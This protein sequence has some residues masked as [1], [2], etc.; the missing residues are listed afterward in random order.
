MKFELEPYRRNIPDDTFIEDLRK[1]AGQLQKEFVTMEEYNKYGTYHSSSI[2]NRFGSWFTALEKAGL[3]KSRSEINI[4]IEKCIAD[5]KRVAQ[6]LGKEEITQKDYSEHGE[7]SPNPLI[8]HFGNWISALE[9]NGLKRTRNYK[10]SEEEYFE[11]LEYIWRTLGRQPRYTEIQKPLSKFSAGAYE[12]NFGT[13]RK[14]L[15]KFVDYINRDATEEEV[16]RLHEETGSS[17]PNEIGLIPLA[18]SCRR[19]SRSISWRMRFLVMRRDDFKCRAC[20]NSPATASGVVL[21]VDHIKAWSD[22]GETTMDN[23]QTLCEQCNIGKGNLS[24]KSNKG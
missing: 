10:V 15:E 23:L 5:L 11:N 7:Y 8:R 24:M 19:S 17:A 1:V 21:H 20:G 14:A 6:Q 22:G 9:Q 2:R 13:W 4:P 12:Q 16:Q 18:D 3:E